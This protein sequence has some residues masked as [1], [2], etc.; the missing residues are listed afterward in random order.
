[1][2]KGRYLRKSTS[3]LTCAI[4][5]VIAIMTVARDYVALA[6]GATQSVARLLISLPYF[7][8]LVV[9]ADA[10]G[11]VTFL[12][13]IVAEVMTRRKRKYSFIQH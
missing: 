13:T 6:D 3:I 7:W 4:A 9:G 10:I 11:S 5:G 2:L 1:M 8:I 12:F